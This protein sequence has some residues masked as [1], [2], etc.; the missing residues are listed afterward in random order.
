MNG[1]NRPKPLRPSHQNSSLS[2]N[3]SYGRTSLPTGVPYSGY[4]DPRFG[5]DGTRS[6]IPLAYMFFNGQSKYVV[7]VGFSSPV[8]H[9]NNFPSR[10][11]HNFRPIPQL[12]HASSASGLGQASRFMSHMY[13]NKKMYDQYGNAFRTSSGFGSNGY[14]SRTSGRG[15]LT[16]DSKYK[17]K[18]QANS[19]LGYGNNL[20][21]KIF[22]LIRN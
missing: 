1:N 4:Q 8:S 16:V 10:R 15:W 12:M 20:F 11:N 2:S 5:F 18:S 22:N 6:L 17:N 7:S 14:D 13:P 3:G 21:G 19:V 9:A